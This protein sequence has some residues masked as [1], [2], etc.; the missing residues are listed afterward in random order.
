MEKGAQGSVASLDGQAADP[1]C[2][3]MEAMEPGCRRRVSCR[4]GWVTSCTANDAQ[5]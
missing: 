5:R 1:Q 2:G 4:P 3:L